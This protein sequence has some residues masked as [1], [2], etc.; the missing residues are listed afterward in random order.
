MLK[1]APRCSSRWRVCVQRPSWDN[2][3]RFED[4]A[5]HAPTDFK[6]RSSFGDPAGVGVEMGDKVKIPSQGISMRVNAS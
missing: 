5:G 3:Q 4:S 6:A 1:F 2:H